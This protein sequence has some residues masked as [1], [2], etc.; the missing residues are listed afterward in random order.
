MWYCYGM[1]TYVLCLDGSNSDDCWL[2][3][4]FTP[5]SVLPTIGPDIPNLVVITHSG[6]TPEQTAMMLRTLAD[7]IMAA[8][9]GG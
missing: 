7:R 3:G 9:H 6:H 1:N 5:E 4:P 2:R 8:H